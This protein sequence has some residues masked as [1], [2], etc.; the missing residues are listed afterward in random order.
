MTNV[1]NSWKNNNVFKKQLQLNLIELTNKT[2]YPSHWNAFISFI[3]EIN[4]KT[5]LDV[6]CGCGSFYKLCNIEF[7]DVKYE[8]IDY[9]IDAIELA[10]KTWSY[11]N[12]S[13]KDYLLLT[14]DEISTYD[15]I[16]LGAILDILPNGDEALDFLLS[17]E[18]KNVIIGRMKITDK[19]SYY[20]TY[21]AYD[22]IMT[23]SYHHNKENF[24]KIC[25]KYDYQLKNINNNFYLYKNQ[26]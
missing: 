25:G 2:T 7:P 10:I 11:N 15:V 8:G 4:P 12:F 24:L 22:E 23:Y 19:P 13:V 18:P 5:I 26:K 21:L 17:L 3:E 9:S 1:I 14:K 6:G 20:E 16:H